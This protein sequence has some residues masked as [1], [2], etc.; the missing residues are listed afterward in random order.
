[1]GLDVVAATNKV[2]DALY[3]KYN[4]NIYRFEEILAPAERGEEFSA[5]AVRGTTLL[6]TSHHLKSLSSFADYAKYNMSGMVDSSYTGALTHEYGHSMMIVGRKLTGK[7]KNPEFKTKILV[8]MKKS[9]SILQKELSSYG[10][11]GY[12][13]FFPEVFVAFDKGKVFEGKLQWVEKEIRPIYKTIL[14]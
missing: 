10:A 11:G 13:E 1:M 14:N 4:A 5:L 6:L 3:N 8:E 12:A 9:K 7:F 2:L